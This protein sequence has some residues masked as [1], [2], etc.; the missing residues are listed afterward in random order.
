MDE[1][2][3]SVTVLFESGDE[4][5]R[6]FSLPDAWNGVHM[7]RRRRWRG[8]VMWSVWICF[9]LVCT[10]QLSASTAINRVHSSKVGGAGSKMSMSTLSGSGTLVLRVRMTAP[11]Y[12]IVDGV[13]RADR[14]RVLRVV[15]VIA[16][17]SGYALPTGVWDRI[18][19]ELITNDR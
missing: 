1:N 4:C 9:S 11:L 14:V 2:A 8:V 15:R 5:T 19:S 17:R 18:A 10:A 7:K 12:K 13:I 3:F 16:A 6:Q